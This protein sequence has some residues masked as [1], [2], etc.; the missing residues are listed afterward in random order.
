MSTAVLSIGSN[1]GDS[2]GHLHM[3]VDQ[4]GDRVIAVSSIYRTA[5]WGGVEQPDFHNAVVIARDE[6]ARP[7]D[8]L[9]LAHLLERRADRVR[10]TTRWGPRTLDVDVIACDNVRDDDPELTLPHPRAHQRAFVLLPWLEIRPNATLPVD[11]REVPIADL[12]SRLSPAERDGVIRCDDAW[13]V[14]APDR[15]GGS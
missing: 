7:H 13:T 4:L 14:P 6:T 8:W 11:G 9:E 2:V 5:P 12:L 3:V 15:V 10:T 1:V